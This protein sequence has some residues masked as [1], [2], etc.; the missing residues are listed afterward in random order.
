M[1]LRGCVK[2]A[3]KGTMSY[4]LC[5]SEQIKDMM[6]EPV[7]REGLLPERDISC[8]EGKNIVCNPLLYKTFFFCLFLAPLAVGQRAHVIVRCASVRALTFPLNIFF[9]ETIYRILMK[10]HRN[11][12]TMVLF[13]IS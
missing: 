13:R 11:V 8:E 7:V 9:T 5:T 6:M 3:V 1:S 2:E 12:P 4:D 10:F